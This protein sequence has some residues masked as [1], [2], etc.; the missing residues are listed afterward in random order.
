MKKLESLRNVTTKPQLAALMGLTAQ[1][2]TNV[3]YRL[4]PVTQYTS[5]TIPKKSGSTRTIYAP[6]EKLKTLQSNLSNLLLD[7]IDDINEPN[8][9]KYT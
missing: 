3:L 5:F 4:K 9:K 6:S 7:C 2:L 8:T 1:F